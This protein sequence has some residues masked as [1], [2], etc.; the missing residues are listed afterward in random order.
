MVDVFIS[1]ARENV[2]T[3]RRLAECIAADGY[4][5]WW[6]ADVPPHLAYGDVIAEEIANAKAVIVV[7]SRHASASHWVRSEADLGREQTKLIQT[8]V[9]GTFPPMPFN[10]IQFADISGWQ[11]EPD[12]PGWMKVKTSLNALCG[13]NS[14]PPRPIPAPPPPPPPMPGPAPTYPPATAPPLA[15]AAVPLAAASGAFGPPAPAA[16]SG[17]SATPTPARSTLR[18]P[19]TSWSSPFRPRRRHPIRRRRG[20]PTPPS[21]RPP[22]STTRPVSTCAAAPP[23]ASRWSAGS[24]PARC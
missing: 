10:Q 17:C 12:H 16:S 5:V 22:R 15:A 11:G 18:P 1:Y 20:P 13:P 7:W 14:A 6:D 21:P 8:S 23:P 2:D 9:D 19:T 4:S 24:M 3:V